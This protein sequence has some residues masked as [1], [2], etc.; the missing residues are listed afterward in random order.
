[1]NTSQALQSFWSSFDLPAYDEKTV[2]D[3]AELPYITY[4]TRD[5]FFGNQAALTASLWYRSS[6]WE[7]IT[8]KEQSIAE[9]I[10]RGGKMLPTDD[11]GMWLKR[12]TPWAQR[13][14][15]PSDDKIRR[16]ILNYEIEFIK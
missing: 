5:D 3:K 13:M 8:L 14:D 12:G 1:M 9:Y 11:G 4:E 6:S 10:T 7:S 15:D 2:P 16:M